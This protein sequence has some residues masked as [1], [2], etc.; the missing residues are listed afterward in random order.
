MNIHP[1][2][3]A[4][5]SLLVRANRI[6]QACAGFF[7]TIR[8]RFY[9]AFGFAAVLTIVG[10]LTALYEFTT[11][12]TTTNE[13]LSHS[14]P[15]T[16]VSLQLSEE[17]SSLVS[18]A[19]RLMMAPDD[20]TRSVITNEIYEQAQHLEDGIARLRN[21]GITAANDIDLADNLLVQRLGALNQAVTDRLEIAN[22]RYQLALSIPAA[23]KA[24]A[25]ALSPLIDRAN[26]E[27][28]TKDKTAGMNSTLESLL[29]FLE[30]Q[31]QATFLVGI[32]TEASLVDDTS[33]LESLRDLVSGAKR[34][35]E[36][37]LPW[38]E[39][40]AQQK[41]ITTLYK[42]LGDLGADDGIITLRT[43]ELTRQHDAQ[44]AFA[45]VQLAAFSLKR[46]VGALVD[47]QDQIAAQHSLRAAGQI[48]EGQAILTVLTLFAIIG[49][50]LIAWLYVDRNIARRLGL[51]SDAMRRIAG[52][53]LSANIQDNSRDE[54]ADMARALQF[55]RQT[56]ADAAIGRQKEIDQSAILESRR[57]SFEAA[58]QRFEHT[59]S[60]V[61]QTL[62]RAAAAMDSRAHD[63]AD[64]SDRN[65]QK[66]LST[67]AA[68]E[69][70]TR[71]VETVA[72]AAEEIAQSIEHI[73]TRVA[74]SATIARQA[75]G[76]AQ[77]ITGAV[78]S[79]SASV[80]EIG[81]V[82]NLIR[83]IATQTNLLALNATIE[84]ARAGDAGRGFAVVAQEVKTLA[85]QTGKATEKITQQIQSIEQTTSHSV[86]AMKTIAATIAQ[87]DVLA[88]DVAA[89]TRQQ[90]SV[91][92]EIARN[93][94]EAAKG[95]R[96]V[97][98]NVSEVSSSA[99]QNGQVASTVLASA[100]E[101]TEQSQ[102]LRQEVELYLAQVRVA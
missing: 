3:S 8:A 21:L 5:S 22:E 99:V 71:N 93:A 38:I 45:A 34:K 42:A 89:A 58:T 27:L 94:N 91:A 88:N 9:C 4:K 100:A 49:A 66:A 24:L 92:Q 13:I 12:G 2:R 26:F 54:I 32:L 6:F 80:E 48:R 60:N 74:E 70:A 96:D 102:R 98:A 35:I 19:P 69:Q 10:S 78:E 56:L 53:D 57:L 75:V 79:L 63:L 81:E 77:A 25:D 82:S 76:E 18:L 44:T 72:A 68:S 17:A 83:T 43:Y 11:I 1:L 62:D 29:Q 23:H 97:S 90:D 15:A 37:G 61:T 52:G 33:R 46:S 51:L 64:S 47:E 67:A 84:A 31:S 65:Q 7:S 87:L 28:M 20:N 30:M 50:G 36:T 16:V 95:T 41:K 14:L 59:I 101:L 40:P 86:E 55:F 85:L 39:D 73:A